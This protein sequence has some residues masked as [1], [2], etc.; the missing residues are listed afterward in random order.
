MINRRVK[1][2]SRPTGVAQAGNFEIDE[3]DVGTLAE[4]EIQ[5]KNGFLSVEPAMRGWIADADNYAS[6]VPIGSVM[7]ALA[8][9]TVVRS[10][11]SDYS[12]GDVVTGWFGWQEFAIVPASSVVRRVIETD[13]PLSLSL[14]L[15]GI[16]GVT[17]YL[18]LTM[19]GQPREG[20]TVLVSTAAGS[21]GSA[22]GQIANILGCRTVG[23]TGGPAKVKLCTDVF[24]Y[25]GAIDY[26]SDDIDAALT[27]F[28][29]EGVDIYYDNTSGAISDAAYRHLA[30]N[31]RVIICGTAAIQN[32]ADWPTGPRLER[33]ILVR[34]ARMQ[35]FVIFD[36][37]DRYDEAVGQLAQWVREGKLAYREDV[38]QGIG[39]CP[40]AL[41]GLYRG[42]N[43]GKRVI[44]L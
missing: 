43:L 12:E 21:V 9:G 38:L 1:L 13:L 44:R 37:M 10:R 17:A 42:E 4:G 30:L 2:K 7:R 15:L 22:A 26:K 28:C 27:H 24:G 3:I 6:P 5:V 41:A 11:H 36:H 40:D 33:H 20:D 18:A 8:V 14:G 35:G 39:A 29:P 25:S 16:N 19:I 23:I 34:R 32:W 31:A